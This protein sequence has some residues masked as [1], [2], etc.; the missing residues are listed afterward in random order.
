[1]DTNSNTV[2]QIIDS[3]RG[4]A[5][6]HGTRFG[7][8]NMCRA[9]D[10]NLFIAPH[11]YTAAEFGAGAGNELGLQESPG[12]MASLRSSSALAVNVFDAWRGSDLSPLADLLGADP[13]ADRLRFEVQYPTGLIGTAP[14]LD[15]VIDQV[16][17]APLAIESKFTEIYSPAHNGFRPSYF[18]KPGLWDGFEASRLLAEGVEDGSMRFDHLGVAQLIKHALGLKN[19]HGADGFR[20]LY[21]WYDWPGAA[22][23]SH[24]DEIDRFAQIVQGA[25][26]F[27]TLTYQELIVGLRKIPEPRPGYLSYLE[28]RYFSDPATRW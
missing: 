27:E 13:A 16:G 26:D 11:R 5:G 1:M 17:A 15:V 7:E 2:E 4:W 3:Q 8:S 23:D 6:R 20:L 12:S 9:V 18:Q 19:A 21:L 22:S 24:R 14:H 25:F 10:D 28:D